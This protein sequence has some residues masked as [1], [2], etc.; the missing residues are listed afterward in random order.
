MSHRAAVGLMLLV[1]LLW[2]SAGV[3]SRQLQQAQ[4]FEVTFWRSAF[5]ALALVP[6]LLW[7][8]GRALFTA[9]RS[10]GWSLWA[11]GVFWAL[12]FSAF[13]LALTMTSV[14]NVLV[15]MSLGPL[16]TALFARSF[17]H[18]RLAART[19]FA[20][21]LASLGIGWMFAQQA[22]LGQGWQG[23]LVALCVPLGA[24]A[25]WCLLQSVAARSP[26]RTGA[27]MLPAVLLG[28]TLSAVC[29]LPLAWP[30]RANAQDLAWLSSLGLFQ[31]AVPCLLVVHLMRVLPAH[32]V[33][34]LGQ[35]ETLLGVLWAWLFAGETPGPA[36][37]MGAALVL[38]A[39]A[40][41]ELLA[42]R[43]PAPVA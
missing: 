23:M 33:A 3:V 5:T 40:I 21:L 36:A 7:L 10:G 19:W 34:L 4:G 16:L 27:D 30:L 6:L 28:A 29:L 25:N 1:T 37:L 11:S 2:S 15:T 24:A 41:N 43:V 8:R 9:L 35:M 22:Q 39:L 18:Q 12:Q 31:L 17:L 42:P 14:A 20:I 26:G 13:M 32:E 38:L